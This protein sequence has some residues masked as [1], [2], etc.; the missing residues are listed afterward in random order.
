[1]VYTKYRKNTVNCSIREESGNQESWKGPLVVVRL[2]ATSAKRFVSI[3]SKSHRDIAIQAVA[4]WVFFVTAYTLP[5]QPFTHL[6]KV[7]KRH[8]LQNFCLSW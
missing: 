5:L 1:M 3:T 7:H 2:D 8:E 6:Y 4:K